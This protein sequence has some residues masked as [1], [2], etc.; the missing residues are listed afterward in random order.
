MT[1]RFALKDFAVRSLIIIIILATIPFSDRPL[2]R[3][4]PAFQQI[5]LPSQ[6]AEGDPLHPTFG[7]RLYRNRLPQDFIDRAT[8]KETRNALAALTADQRKAYS[9]TLEQIIMTQIQRASRTISPA[10]LNN[11][12]DRKI[13]QVAPDV[14]PVAAV[15]S[16]GERVTL[17]A[18]YQEG[19]IQTG[20]APQSGKTSRLNRS[21]IQQGN[22][23]ATI[24]DQIAGNFKKLPL[25]AG[26]KAS[27]S[28]MSYSR[29]GVTLAPA[30]QSGDNDFDGFADSFE[31]IVAD[32]FMPAYAVSEGE[33]GNFTFFGDFV[34]QTPIGFNGQQPFTYFRVTPLGFVTSSTQQQYGALRVDYLTLWDRD[35][36]F[37]A[38]PGPC[39][40]DLLGLTEFINILA[41]HDLDNERSATLLLA[42]VSAPNTY[43]T[44]P[45]SYA[46]Y[47]Y[48]LAAHEGF[49]AGFD[50]SVILYPQ[51]PVL[52][53][54][55]FLWFLSKFKHATYSF[56]PNFY[57]L[58]PAYILTSAI[59]FFD[60]LYFTDQI[61]Y[62]TWLILTG[63][64]YDTYFGC[65]TEK[66][67]MPQFAYF[68]NP[69][70]NVGEVNTPINGSRFI[71]DNSDR[72]L[73]LRSKLENPIPW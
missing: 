17:T 40:P 69:R 65:I 58:A 22:H 61:D 62:W 73:N 72:A 16:T 43:N 46:A 33:F 57:P 66:F 25:T 19:R 20:G 21:P 28:A 14:I 44:D 53:D 32:L 37:V 24:Q 38:S 30:L 2:T 70:I 11:I 68:P 36:G 12:T 71:Q 55:H 67:T 52:P 18:N 8:S 35:L 48:Y 34:P 23:W 9:R 54:N 42:P 60:W 59:A 45:A 39:A 5:P 15:K 31:S 4:L 29:G 26:D 41:A 63:L 1:R 6:V 27:G 64:A 47:A 10:G 49:P 3:A 13:G 7:Q 50:H 56:N 51:S